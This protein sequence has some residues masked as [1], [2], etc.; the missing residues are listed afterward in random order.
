[1]SNKI[2]TLFARPTESFLSYNNSILLFKKMNN[3][4]PLLSLIDENSEITST[5][6]LILQIVIFIFLP[7]LLYEVPLYIA[8]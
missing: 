1:M 8:L 7:V 2:K 4:S 6:Y 3:L 5:H